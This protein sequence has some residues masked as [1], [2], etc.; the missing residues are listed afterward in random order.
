MLGYVAKRIVSVIPVA[1]IVAVI[2][3]FVL[4]LGSADPAAVLAGEYANAETIARIRA[5]LGLDEPLPTQFVIWFGGLLQGDLGTSIY[6][7]RP[8]LD[9]ILQRVGPS[10]HLGVLTLAFSVL[11]AIP[12]GILA[13]WKVGTWIDRAVMF[14]SVGSISLPV[15]VLAYLL[16]ALFSLQLEW[17][18]VQG[19]RPPSDGLIPFLRQLVLPVLALSPIFIAFI[20]RMTRASMLDVMGQDY[21]RTAEAKGLGQTA[22]LLRHA[23]RNAAVPIVTVVGSAFGLLISGVVVTETV[24]AIP[25][26]GRLTSDAIFQRDYP[27]IQGAMLFLSFIYILVNLVVDILYTVLDPRIRY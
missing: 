2:A 26:L 17:L 8:V 9:L 5:E 16:V 10:L 4:R 7:Q 21:I 27:V 19:Y 15:F 23:F 18:P 25:G 1:L 13:A 24:F 14:M 3:F 20:A 11:V 6:S 12:L 22:V